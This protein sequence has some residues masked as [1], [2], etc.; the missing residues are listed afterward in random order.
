MS[1]ARVRVRIRR[2]VLDGVD[3]AAGERLAAGI[4]RE[5]AVLLARPGAMGTE[6]PR[7]TASVA[8]E[9]A[10][11]GGDELRARLAEALAR[12]VHERIEVRG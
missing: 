11:R 2:L 6:R 4:E 12:L 9:L 10:A 1:A 7:T 8:V 3:P 5:L